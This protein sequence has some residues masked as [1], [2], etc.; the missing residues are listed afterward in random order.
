MLPGEPL[1]TPEVEQAVFRQRGFCFGSISLPLGRCDSSGFSLD[2]TRGKTASQVQ[3]NHG[4]LILAKQFRV[5]MPGRFVKL[6]KN[7]DNN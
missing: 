2:V 7:N 6:L 4:W 5:V 1:F 3:D